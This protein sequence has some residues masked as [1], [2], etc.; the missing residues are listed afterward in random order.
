M[1]RYNYAGTL[2]WVTR[3]GGTG[4]DVGTSITSFP[5]GSTVVTGRFRS[6]ATFGGLGD[7][8][9][10][11]LT[12]MGDSDMFVARYNLDGT[13]AWVRQTGGTG[14]DEGSGVAAFANDGLVVSGVFTGMAVFG[15]EEANQ[16]TLTASGASDIFVL[17]YF[18]FA[19]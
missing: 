11:T 15:P 7:S 14:V 6:T 17:K 8:F 2:I 1:A 9:S 10:D 19:E 5:E 13:L 18:P 4:L 16:Q 3:A 12:A